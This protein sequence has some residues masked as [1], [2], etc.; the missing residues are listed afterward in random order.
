MRQSSGKCANRYCLQCRSTGRW[1]RGSW[2]TPGFRKKA[3]PSFGIDWQDRIRACRASV[4]GLATIQ[5]CKVTALG[6]K[7][8]TMGPILATGL[9]KRIRFTSYRSRRWSPQRPVVAR[10][11]ERCRPGS[12]YA[13]TATCNAVQSRERADGR[14]R[15]DSYDSL[16]RP[17]S[18]IRAQGTPSESWTQ[19]GY[20][21][22]GSSPP[23]PATGVAPNDF[24]V[25][26]DQTT[27]GAGEIVSETVIDGLGRT[28]QTHQ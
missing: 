23:C 2:M 1:W 21:N 15:R 19:Y 7:S 22:T 27:K 26:Q 17:T 3:D 6:S 18:V 11:R 20:C 16:N 10:N 24:Q 4:W 8:G 5:P 28:A 13:A 9:L 14:F 25:K 12:A